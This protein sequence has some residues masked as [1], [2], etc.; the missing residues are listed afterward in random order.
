MGYSR[1]VIVSQLY[2]II[3]D[4]KNKFG[5]NTMINK[6]KETVKYMGGIFLLAFFIGG[7]FILALCWEIFKG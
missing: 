5:G 3:V 4:N 2:I 1:I 7:P 6:I